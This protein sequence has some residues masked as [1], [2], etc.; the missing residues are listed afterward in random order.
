MKNNIIWTALFLIIVFVLF[1]YIFP[2]LN[3]ENNG[4]SLYQEVYNQRIKSKVERKFIDSPN[5]ALKK[6]IYLDDNKEEKELVFYAEY[7]NMYDSL[8]IGDSIFKKSGTLYYRIKFKT[9]EKDRLFK[10]YTLCKDSIR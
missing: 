1:L 4:C 9:T 8:S 7:K 6:I 5:H 10:F 2:H 3:I